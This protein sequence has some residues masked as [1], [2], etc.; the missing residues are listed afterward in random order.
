MYKIG[1]PRRRQAR[2]PEWDRRR[3]ALLAEAQ[4]RIRNG[5]RRIAELD[6]RR[7]RYVNASSFTGFAPRGR[8]DDMLSIAPSLAYTGPSGMSTAGE[9]LATPSVTAPSA[10][11]QTPDEEVFV[12]PVNSGDEAAAGAFG[13]V[14]KG[15]EVPQHERMRQEALDQ[16][17]PDVAARYTR[18]PDGKLPKVAPK[19]RIADLKVL[20]LSTRQESRAARKK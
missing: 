8:F 14:K 2:E 12:T 4:T 20:G 16:D 10:Q 15:R 11:A 9:S 3:K 5:E 13:R 1:L 6:R 7:L 19:Q 18:G 17:R